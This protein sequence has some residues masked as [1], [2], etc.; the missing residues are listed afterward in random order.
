MDQ[1]T[2]VRQSPS[3]SDPAFISSFKL[4]LQAKNY[5]PATIRNYLVDISK[6]LDFSRTDIFSQNSIS[7]YV[8]SLSKN[9]NTSRYL[10][11]LNQFC[12]YALDQHLVTQNPLK[13][14]LKNLRSSSKPLDPT[15]D[16]LLKLYQQNLI[17]HN[18]APVTIKNYLNDLHQYINWLETQKGDAQQTN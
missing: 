5:S 13:A 2:S 1:L 16:D 4:W 3:N 17:K 18:T 10:S 14:A 6:Y 11:S 12:L 7:S 9:E 8:A 15:L